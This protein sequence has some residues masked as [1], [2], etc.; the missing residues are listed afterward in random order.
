MKHILFYLALTV[1]LLLSPAAQA[2]YAG[3]TI[4]QVI[5]SPAGRDSA[6]GAISDTTVTSQGDDYSKYA[7]KEESGFPWKWFIA[8][9]LAVLMIILFALSRRK[10]KK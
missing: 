10:K 8:L 1:T 5:V 9:D 6:M 2:K 4:A 3:S 7:R